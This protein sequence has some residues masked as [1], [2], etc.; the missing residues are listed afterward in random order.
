[1]E[2]V[3]AKKEQRGKQTLSTLLCF[4]PLTLGSPQAA[5]VP[6]LPP[7]TPPLPS[8]SPPLC[9][10]THPSW[11]MK[12]ST[13]RRRT[14]TQ[15]AMTQKRTCTTLMTTLLSSSVGMEWRSDGCTLTALRLHRQ[16]G[17]FCHWPLITPYFKIVRTFLVS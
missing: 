4:G 8:A 14:Q 9:A 1:M 6:I 2:D 15:K 16:K 3:E 13:P 12:V 11:V 10:V 17:S 5:Q 7:P